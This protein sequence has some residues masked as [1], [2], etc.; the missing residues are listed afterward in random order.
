M[1]HITVEVQ[2]HEKAQLLYRVLQSLDFVI[3]I[4]TDDQEIT[5]DLWQE[6]V[7]R[8]DEFF[9]YAGL[10]SDREISVTTLRQQAWPR[11]SV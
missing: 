10:W 8:T 7:D 6:T 4:S 9:S 5:Q 1:Q 2:D 3:H 11:Q